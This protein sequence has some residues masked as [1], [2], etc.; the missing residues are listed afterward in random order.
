MAEA[1]GGRGR[2]GGGG[3][4]GSSGGAGVS[5]SST[6]NNNRQVLRR[7]DANPSAAILVNKRQTGNPMLKFIKNVRWMFVDDLVPDYQVIESS[8]EEEKI[9]L[10]TA[11]T[12]TLVLST[13][14]FYIFSLLL[15]TTTKQTKTKQFIKQLNSW[16]SLLSHSS[17]H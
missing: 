12:D 14:Y 3:G 4:G 16:V 13:F 10:A 2:G 6:G 17:C 8:E 5:R 1:S 15:H 7:K 9:R 11:C